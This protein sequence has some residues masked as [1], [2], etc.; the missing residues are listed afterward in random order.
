VFDASRSSARALRHGGA[1]SIAMSKS[2]HGQEQRQ[3]EEGQEQQQGKLIAEQKAPISL[4]V[5]VC[6]LAQQG[7]QRKQQQQQR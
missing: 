5:A 2:S 6:G 4:A 7:R 1:V 3:V